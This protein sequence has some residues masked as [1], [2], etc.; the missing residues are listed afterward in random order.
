MKSGVTLA[1]AIHF[2]KEGAAI[3]SILWGPNDPAFLLF[4]KGRL[5][6]PFDTVKAHLGD[7]PF[8]V[9]DH[10][11]AYYVTIGEDHVS[12]A[13]IVGYQFSQREILEPVWQNF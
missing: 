10:L 7:T 12:A 3:R 2:A 9:A 13:C 5:V 4:V 6:Q 11:D 8:Q 1:E